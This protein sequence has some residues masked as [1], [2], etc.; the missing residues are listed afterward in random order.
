MLWTT[1]A[2]HLRCQVQL[3]RQVGVEARLMMRMGKCFKVQVVCVKNQRRILNL[4]SFIILKTILKNKPQKAYSYARGRR[5]K[6][7][8]FEL[9]KKDDI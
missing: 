2:E 4:G 7:F 8:R 3:R 6:Y 1:P 9:P 5:M